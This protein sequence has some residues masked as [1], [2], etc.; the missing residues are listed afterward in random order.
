M[1]SAY[2]G[3]FNRVLVP[4]AR[5]LTRIGFSPN[6][7]SIIGFVSSGVAAIF[8]SLSE[9]G[10]ALLLMIVASLFDALDGVVARL[11]NTTT[12]LGAYLDSL[13][14]RYSD[15][16]ILIGLMI[17]MGGHYVLITVVIV[18]SL[19]VSYARAKAE[20]LGVRG[21]VGLAERAE[22]LL[23]LIFATFLEWRGVNAYYPALL[24]LAVATHFTVLQRMY[25]LYGSLGK[26]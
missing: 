15:S 2:K 17:Y 18:G 20:T 6:I 8:L 16:F 4:V 12:D 11:S 7:L 14:D 26:K 21:D 3:K 24:I 9:L 23:I 1:L 5:W 22:R 19:L 13:F 10:L 25:Y